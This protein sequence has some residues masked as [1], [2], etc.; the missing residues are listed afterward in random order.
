MKKKNLNVSYRNT[1]INTQVIN[2]NIQYL[3]V[4]GIWKINYES[5]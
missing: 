1:N 4:R 3:Q 5:E 2:I